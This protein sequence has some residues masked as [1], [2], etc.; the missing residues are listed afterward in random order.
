VGGLD[1]DPEIIVLEG[2]EQ[3]LGAGFLRELTEL[4]GG[5]L[6]RLGVPALQLAD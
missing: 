4:T 6:T 3:G 2:L 1:S 5:G